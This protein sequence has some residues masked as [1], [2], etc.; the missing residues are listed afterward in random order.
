MRL[1]ET[2]LRGRGVR[3]RER[4]GESKKEESKGWTKRESE[5]RSEEMRE[6]G[7]SIPDGS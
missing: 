5:S 7:T 3:K 4:E 2:L 6:K 1:Y